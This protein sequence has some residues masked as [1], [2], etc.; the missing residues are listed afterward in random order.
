MSVVEKVCNKD[1]NFCCGCR[2]GISAYKQ[3]MTFLFLLLE[4]A[5]FF[6]FFIAIGSFTHS[7]Y[8]LVKSLKEKVFQL[9]YLKLLNLQQQFVRFKK[10]KHT[11]RLCLKTN[12]SSIPGQF[13]KHLR[14]Q[15]PLKDKFIPSGL[16][17]H[18]QEL[19]ARCNAHQ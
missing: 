18:K 12:L 9:I 11:H 6:K 8:C 17:C 10:I 7:S 5:C 16:I 1:C 4:F 3:A 15:S 13:T 2:R 14:T 19:R